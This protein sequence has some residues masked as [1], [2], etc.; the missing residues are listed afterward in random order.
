MPQYLLKTLQQSPFDSRIK[1]K[2]LTWHKPFIMHPWCEY[3]PCMLQQFPTTIREEIEDDNC[4]IITPSCN[5]EQQDQ[6]NIPGLL[7]VK[8]WYFQP[9]N[10]QWSVL[11]IHRQERSSTGVTETLNMLEITP[12][13]CQYSHGHTCRHV[14][15]S[16]IPCS[17][18]LRNC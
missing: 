5:A 16:Q 2:F 10:L 8:Q 9:S 11:P 15:P 14:W 18:C 17:C 4:K 1:F 6:D 13:C 3:L 12:Q 7:N